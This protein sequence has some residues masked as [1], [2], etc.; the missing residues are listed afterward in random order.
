[1]L[2]K[3]RDGLEHNGQEDEE[4]ASSEEEDFMSD[5][6]L[7]GAEKETTR[8]EAATTYSEKRRRKLNEAKERGKIQNRA[9]REKGA[10]I[11]GLSKS[12]IPE[13]GSK[14]SLEDADDKFGQSNKALKMMMAMGYQ[15]GKGLGRGENEVSE[16]KKDEREAE[17]TSKPIIEPLAIDERWMGAK[18]KAGIGRMSAL[19]AQALSQDIS[20]AS[21]KEANAKNTLSKEE[22]FRQRTRDEQNI[23]HYERL[24]IDARSTCEDLDTKLGVQFSPLW[25]NPESLSKTPDQLPHHVASLVDF[26]FQGLDDNDKDPDEQKEAIARAQESKEF[27]QLPV[28]SAFTH[29]KKICSSI[30]LFFIVKSTP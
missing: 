22:V 24:L 23:R 17:S 18:A 4:G 10:R 27:C 5:A 7:T 9:E 12:L 28:S 16:A 13:P 26:A 25:L 6:F 19:S 14:R 30:C 2:G 15:Q 1:M 21:S 20:K 11:L 8:E 29:F 3:G